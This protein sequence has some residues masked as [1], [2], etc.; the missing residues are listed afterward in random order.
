MKALLPTHYRPDIDGLRAIAVLAVVLYHAFPNA[1][2]GGFIGVDIFFVISGYLISNII[3]IKIDSDTFSFLDFYG[4]RIRRIFPSLFLV[5]VCTLIFG[6]FALLGDEYRQLGIHTAASGFFVENLLLWS[7]SGYF[8]NSSETKILLHL[9]SLGIEEQFYIIWPVLLWLSFKA[10][11]NFLV[12][13]ALIGIGSFALNIFQVNIAFNL[14]ADFYSPQTRF[15][16]LLMGAC[17][18]YLGLNESKK[19]SGLAINIASIVGFLLILI[20]IVYINKK[21]SF[22]GWWALI[23]TLGA[24]LMIGSGPKAVINKLILSN[25][26]LVWIGLIS[27]PLYLWHWPLLSF[28]RIMEGGMPSHFI[29]AAI[30]LTSFLLAYVSYRFV[31][32]PI[33]F[34]KSQQKK[35]LL[36]ALLMFIISIMGIYVGIKNGFEDRSSISSSKA[37]NAQFVGS[38]WKYSTNE[39]CQKQYP[40]TPAKNYA[41]WFCVANTDKPPTLLILGSSYA[42]QLYPGIIKNQELKHHSVLSIGACSAQWLEPPSSTKAAESSYPCEAIKAYEQQVFIDQIIKIFIVRLNPITTAVLATQTL[43][44]IILTDKPA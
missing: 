7:E 34:G 13:T 32:I 17:L 12:V 25:R 42:N 22:P 11:W 18:A 19:F 23:P 40:F 24:I 44:S 39:V 2:P 4:H 27:Y 3:F 14:V 9:W 26:I 31:E 20:G 29:R 1:L 35:A 30:V 5:L 15:W 21:L 10:K 43:H 36:L 6:W 33:R 8:D 37:I 38:M 16:E 28:A 41:W